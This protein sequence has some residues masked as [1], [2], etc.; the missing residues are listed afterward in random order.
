MD[1][2]KMYKKYS[3]GGTNHELHGLL[4]TVHQFPSEIY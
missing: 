2:F 3:E 1:Y 4:Q